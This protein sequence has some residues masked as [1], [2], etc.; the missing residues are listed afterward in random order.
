MP[1]HKAQT[2]PVTLHLTTEQV[3]ALLRQVM[4]APEKDWMDDPRILQMLAERDHQVAADLRAGKFATLT[5]LQAR[6]SK[7]RA[8]VQRQPT[9]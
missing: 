3:K 4:G 8:K 1:K 2:I 5:E 7:R 6:W 9:S